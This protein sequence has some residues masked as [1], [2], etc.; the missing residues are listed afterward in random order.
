M[1]SKPISTFRNFDKNVVCEACNGI[2]H[3]KDKCWSL[4]LFPKWHH[5][6]R[7]TQAGKKTCLMGNGK[8]TNRSC[9]GILMLMLLFLL[10][11]MKLN[12][13]VIF[14]QQLLQLLKMIPGA[15]KFTDEPDDLDSPFSSMIT[16]FTTSLDTKYG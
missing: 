8:V 16:C 3:T 11:V 6:Y 5:K 1:Y 14:T 12:D 13:K 10:N 9:Q 2:G 7:K 4:I 15:S